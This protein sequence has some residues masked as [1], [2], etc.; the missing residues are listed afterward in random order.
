MRLHVGGKQMKNRNWY[1]EE[2]I[3]LVALVVTII[4][5]LILA[6]I[7]I[8][9]TLGDKGIINM[10]KEAGKNYQDAANYEQA[11]L[12]NLTNEATNIIG[13]DGNQ[14]VVPDMGKVRI[15]EQGTVDTGTIEASGVKL[16]TINL[17]NTYTEEDHARLVFYKSEALSGVLACYFRDEWTAFEVTGNTWASHIFNG[18]NTTSGNNRLYYWVI[19]GLEE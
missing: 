13:S 5:L 19:G 14:S 2:G 17:Q 6:G 10:A 16:I 1:K 9:L 7:T 8:T 12:G 11:L 3:T 15:L 4:I 18:S